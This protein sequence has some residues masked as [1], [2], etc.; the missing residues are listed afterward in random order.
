M[1]YTRRHR[2]PLRIRIARMPLTRRRA[3]TSLLG[4][5][6]LV[7]LDALGEW[8]VRVSGATVPGSVVGMLLL[9]VLLETRVVPLEAVRPAA[10]LLVR[11]LALL[12]VP[13]GAA[14]LVYWGAVRGELPAIA[15]AALASLVA[16]LA[17]VGLAVQRFERAA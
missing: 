6:L 12:Y 13:A 2:R 10:E 14:L 1:R 5:A 8:V 7:A 11:H 3:I 17:V 16:V 15:A 9:T 4:L